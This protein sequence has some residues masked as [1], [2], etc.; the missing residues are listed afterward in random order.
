[1]LSYIV[2]II[3]YWTY[4]Y[5][6]MNT[7]KLRKGKISL[8][9]LGKLGM[10]LAA[11]FADRGFDVLGVDIN[12]ETVRMVNAGLSPN[13]EYGLRELIRKNK[14]RLSATTD[15]SLAIAE[16]DVTF[17]LVATPSDTY[18]NFSNK[19]VESA[20]KALAIHLKNSKKPFHIFVISSTVAPTSVEKRIIPLIERHSGRKLDRGF[21]VCYVPDFVALGTVIKNFMNPDFVMIGHTD[22]FSGS[23]IAGIYEKMCMNNPPIRKMSLVNA[24]VAKIALN[25][26]MTVKISFGNALANLCSRIP[27]A[28]VDVITETIGID[29]RISPHYLKGG[30]AYGGT[31]FPRDVAAWVAI[32]KKYGVSHDLQSAIENINE[33]QDAYLLSMVEQGIKRSKKKAVSILGLSFKHGTPVVDRSPAIKLISSLVRRGVHVTVYDPLAMENTRKIFGSKIK[34]ADSVKDCISRSAVCVITTSDKEFKKL[35]ENY[36]LHKPT[37]IID[38]W[39][40]VRFCNRFKNVRHIPLG[41]HTP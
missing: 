19:Y 34:Y 31:C 9:G 41:V 29:K 23:Y 27:G 36:I 17:I 21:G 20:T 37:I 26:Y 22:D 10:S 32:A 1:M 13:G 7:K 25:N 8:V 33:D 35:K 40:I 15:H 24:E 4:Y 14:D 5:S 11:C 39:R 12:K 16:T 18:G 30:L 3:H 6:V 28:D 38:C 2:V